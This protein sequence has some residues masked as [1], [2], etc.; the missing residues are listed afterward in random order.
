MPIRF[1]S[2][3]RRLPSAAAAG[4]AAPGQ[5]IVLFALFVVVLMVL[6]GSAYDYA[7]IV[8]DDAQLQNS[9]DAAALAGSNALSAG[10]GQAGVTPVGDR[11]GRHGRLP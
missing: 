4:R 11:F 7:S 8:V 3:L 2:L 5:I 1:R 10:A 6:A 9:V